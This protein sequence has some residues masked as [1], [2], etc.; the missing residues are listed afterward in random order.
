MSITKIKWPRGL[1]TNGWEQMRAEVEGIGRDYVRI[2][3][4]DVSVVTGSNRFKCPQ[5]LFH[6]LTG[7]HHSFFITESTLAGHLAEATVMKRW[8]GYTPDDEYQSLMN[9]RDGIRLRKVRK[10]DFFL[11]NSKYPNL[12]ASLDYVFVGKQYSPWTGA[13]YHP[14]TPNE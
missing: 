9:V 5:R 7:F 2:G 14:L 12:S 6:H 11:I 10:A 4:S 8:E 1:D 3:A 13:K